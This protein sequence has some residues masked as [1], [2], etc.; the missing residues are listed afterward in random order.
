M[1]RSTK[2]AIYKDK[3]HRKEDYWRVH[4]RV[5]KQINKHFFTSATHVT[6]HYWC[7]EP[8]EV[9]FD[10]LQK[11]LDQGMSHEE[12][13][14]EANCAHEDDW[15]FEKIAGN[16]Y[17]SWWEEPE[18]KNPKELINDYD[19]SDFRSDYEFDR[20]RGYY[21][22]HKGDKGSETWKEWRN[23]WAEKLRRK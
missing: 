20:R 21:G 17:K 10:T 1:S 8:D 5:N 19:Y 16:N 9:Y 2:K 4:R 13:G 18:F 15:W 11:F 12:A 23:S 6:P 3:G 14:Y 22:D 7:F